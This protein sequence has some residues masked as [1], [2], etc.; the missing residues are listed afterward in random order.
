M[1]S[2]FQVLRWI[3]FI[4]SDI[5]HSKYLHLFLLIIGY[6]KSKNYFI[7][8]QYPLAYIKKIKNNAKATSNEILHTALSQGIHDFCHYSDCPIVKKD[9]EN[10]RCRACTTFGFPSKPHVDI[11][12]ACHNG[13]CVCV[14]FILS[15]FI[16]I[17]SIRMGDLVL[18]CN[19]C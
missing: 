11:N 3:S 19:S 1:P 2:N 12:E 4:T 14:F 9:G 7:F 13:W 6:V 18:I 8:D 5:S 15:L 17:D 16:V 10:I